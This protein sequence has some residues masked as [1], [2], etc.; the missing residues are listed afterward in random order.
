MPT[1]LFESLL[2]STKLLN[3]A[4]VRNFEFIAGKNAKTLSVEYCSFVQCHILIKYSTFCLSVCA[5]PLN[6]FLTNLLKIIT[7]L[8]NAKKQANYLFPE[9]LVEKLVD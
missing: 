5:P 2:C 9:F 3:M 1:S 8:L 7:A 6:Q 4:K